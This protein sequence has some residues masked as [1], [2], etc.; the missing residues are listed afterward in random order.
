DRLAL[1]EAGRVITEGTPAQLL[2]RPLKS[3]PI[4]IATDDAGCAKWLAAHPEVREV[5][6]RAGRLRVRL[7]AHADPQQWAT[8]LQADAAAR[9]MQ[10]SV[11]I[12]PGAELEDVF[13]AVLEEQ[14]AAA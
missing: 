2:A 9:G 4:E 12:H 3:P 11:D 6:P 5:L 1:M 13:V 10:L 8:Q 7:D 14:A